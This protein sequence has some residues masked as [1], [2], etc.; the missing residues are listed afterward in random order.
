MKISEIQR[1]IEESLANLSAAT[2]P[3][4]LEGLR[5]LPVGNHNPHVSIRNVNG[6]RK[7][8]DDAAASYFD[9]D[10]CEVVIQFTPVEAP[11]HEDDPGEAYAPDSDEPAGLIDPEKPL[12]QLVE[13]LGKIEGTRPFIGLKWFRDQ[14]LPE[15]PY[16]WARNPSALRSVL[17]HAIDQ[18][19]ILTSQVPNPNQPHH[20][21]A[22]IRLNRKHPL[23]QPEAR[24][25]R[26]R[27]TP[28]R[29]RGGSIS[30]T[31][32]GDRR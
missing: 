24:G 28:V 18:R 32:L 8:R 5:H 25:R 20:P 10:R 22:A 7:V 21:V 9:P 11:G 27:F 15:C 16:G 30:A 6:G 19:M 23:F 31:V 3:Q 1:D 12:G 26:D 13:E 2:L 29:I 14:V 4:G 17:G